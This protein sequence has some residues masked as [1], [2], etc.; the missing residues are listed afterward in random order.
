MS[1]APQAPARSGLRKVSF[2]VSFNE[3]GLVLIIFLFGIVLTKFGGSHPDR[4]SGNPVSNFLNANTLFEIATRSAFFAVMSVGMT[5]VIITAGIDLSVGSIYALC[6]VGTALVLRAMGHHGGYSNFTIVIVG[7]ICCVGIGSLC[8]LVNGV[9]TVL[10]DVHPFI[11]TL[12]TFWI[13]RG[14]AFVISQAVSISTPDALI[15]V[16]TASLGFKG[17]SPVPT[18]VMIVTTILGGIYLTKTPMGRRIFAVGGNLEASRYAGLPVKR[19]ITGVYVLAGLCS[20]IAALLAI[21]YYGS[22]SSSDGTGYE[23][24]V[25]AAAVVGGASLL[26]G[27]GSALGAVLGAV[28]ISMIRESIDILHLNSNYEQ[29]IVGLAIVIAVVLDRASAKLKARQLV[30]VRSEKI[31]TSDTQTRAALTDQSDLKQ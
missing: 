29:I 28:L 20:G 24:Y 6:S 8:G 14:I 18:I 4:Y 16:I 15:N 22:A 13:F 10:L 25:I 5:A 7:I 31:E 27:K 19:I 12:G 11:I 26:G 1:L 9:A 21:G 17:L 2:G 30:S 23:L 3:I